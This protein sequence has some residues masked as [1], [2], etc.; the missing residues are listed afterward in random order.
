MSANVMCKAAHD[1]I[2]ALKTIRIEWQEAVG[3]GVSLDQVQ[4]SVGLI[5]DDVMHAIGLNQEDILTN[6]AVAD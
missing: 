5:L 3:D 4:G 2:K 1:V 6:Q